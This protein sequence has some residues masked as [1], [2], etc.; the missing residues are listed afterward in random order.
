MK[1][2]I[3]IGTPKSGSSSIQAFLAMN[4]K[5]LR[6]RGVI[7]APF[8]RAFGSQYEFAVTALEACDQTVPPELE[9]RR[10]R[11]GARSDQ[12]NYVA[13]Y[14]DYLD[15]LLAQSTGTRF[16]GSS[17][18]L[19][20]WLRQPRQIAM[21][22]QFLSARFRSV[23]YLVYL[24]PQHELVTSTYS[25]AIRR[26]ATH[27]FAT[28]LARHS[29]VNHWALLKPWVQTVTR[30]RLCVR[31]TCRDAL[32]GGDL[33]ND[34][35]KY[36]QIPAAG[37]PRPARVNAALCVSELALRRRLNQILPVLGRDGRHHWLYQA[38]L[39]S[40]RPVL[41]RNPHPLHLTEGECAQIKAR[42]A[43]GNEKLRKKF[44]PTRAELF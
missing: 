42:N 13:A 34:F 22:D 17:E 10:L 33:L 30:A 28:H 15:N 27:D 4:R 12:T 32:E 38:A 39:Q 40:L 11:F 7:Y 2:I 21:L 36:A 24:R 20:A 35:C 5:E 41:A 44:F 14:H 6:H 1:A 16:I 18:H 19:H 9:R 25:E 26:G 43:Q 3:H 31:L 8:N 37:L 23:E 29:V